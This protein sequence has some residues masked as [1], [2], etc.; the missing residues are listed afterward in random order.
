MEIIY[1]LVVV[2]SVVRR[3]V[4][5]LRIVG[6]NAPKDVGVGK[7]INVRPVTVIN[8]S[9]KRA[10]DIGQLFETYGVPFLQRSSFTVV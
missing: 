10:M 2:A 1:I 3:I 6:K 8:S 9:V 7:I 4:S 5:F